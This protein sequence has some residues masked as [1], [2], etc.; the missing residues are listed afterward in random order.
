MINIQS[1]VKQLKN[2]KYWDELLKGDA[3]KLPYTKYEETDH[4]EIKYCFRSINE[5]TTNK[6]WHMLSC[7]KY[8]LHAMLTLCLF[9]TLH[10]YTDHNDMI[11]GISH[12]T[13]EGDNNKKIQ[14]IPIRFCI[15]EKLSFQEQILQL[16]DIV[17]QTAKMQC[18]QFD[19]I[20]NYLHVN[21]NVKLENLYNVISICNTKD[22][23]ELLDKKDTDMPIYFIKEGESL[24]CKLFYIADKYQINSIE[25][26]LNTL[27]HLI[28]YIT[29]NIDS[30]FLDY[31]KAF[32]QTELSKYKII[33][34][35]RFPYLE[36]MNIPQLLNLQKN[37]TRIAIECDYS[38]LSY[39][40]LFKKSNQIA[41]LLL[42]K[43]VKKGAIIG[44]LL[45]RS[46]DY[47]PIIIGVLRIGAVC[48]PLDIDFPMERN[49]MI[50]EDS[51]ADLLLT[52]DSYISNMNLQYQVIYLDKHNLEGYTFDIDKCI[53]CNPNNPAYI[54]YTSGST[55]K[56]KGVILTHRGIVNQIF[57]KIK[58]L[59][60]SKDDVF[61]HNF[62][63]NVVAS[64]W[65]NFAPLY[66]GAKIIVQP[67]QMLKNPY[68]LMSSVN[69]TSVTVL[70]VVPSV[71]NSYLNMIES[72][73]EKF[74]FKNLK[75][76]LV[77]GEKLGNYYVNQF[78]RHYD[79]NL[80]NAY[81]QS[82]CSD[83][84]LHYSFM[85]H[86][87]H[88][89]IPIGKPA[90]NTRV[91]VF[92]KNMLLK[93]EMAIGE[94]YIAG[95]GTSL[96]YINRPELTHSIWVENPLVKGELLYNTKDMVRL[97]W[98]GNMEFLGRRDNQVKIK[99]NRVELDD[100]G[101]LIS[102]YP[103]VDKAVVVDRV[104]NSGQNVLCAF[105][106]SSI[107]LDQK[108]IFK[109]LSAKAPKYM[110]PNHI[111]QIDD[112]PE[113]PNGKADRIKLQSYLI[114][115][116]K[117]YINSDDNKSI[118]VFLVDLWKDLLDIDVMN[119]GD[120]F[121]QL[122]GDSMLMIKMFDILDLKYPGKI[123][124]GDLFIYTNILKLSEFLEEKVK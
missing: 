45:P 69:N 90:N 71:L 1:N 74:N 49:N 38:S 118:K 101:L 116:S 88:F 66:L 30:S 47:I 46:I 122:G 63:F 35:T 97:W 2:T 115:Y 3:V 100:I 59:E 27:L 80:V 75:L 13:I 60:L 19:E 85:H 121:F 104:D 107:K 103:K 18:L 53:Q 94:L 124:I 93:P 77:T 73:V 99:G 112:I 43:G 12:E 114:P 48:L 40:E 108:D 28:D 31:I 72:G 91:Y 29:F 120:N 21:Y 33:N 54:I 32:N 39:A 61:S 65:L 55:G 123:K 105:V 119:E 87:N 117:E 22:N 26:Y 58:E 56:S 98:D 92:G 78:F 51:N 57:I 6:L 68:E 50:I 67:K 102:E 83:D 23:P 84:T 16:A 37:N 8:Q 14:I 41:G 5:N 17:K 111:I 110:I 82:E 113:T 52:C 34:E 7:S 25:N 86:S 9:Y 64:I 44:I 76:I 79:I 109:Y 62:S 70:S 15:D 11:L 95:D 20:K 96:G 42:E 81:G 89:R 36:N 106:T 10:I 24:V 4:H